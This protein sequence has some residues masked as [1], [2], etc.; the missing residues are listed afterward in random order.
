M[1]ESVHHWCIHRKDCDN[2]IN[3]LTKSKVG[4]KGY[5]VI[6]AF[7]HR[8]NR[9]LVHGCWVLDREDATDE[10]HSHDKKTQGKQYNDFD[11]SK[12]S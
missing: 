3:M 2:L 11:F 6:Y 4:N 9:T 5:R 12:I 1:E 8:P 10:C 7:S